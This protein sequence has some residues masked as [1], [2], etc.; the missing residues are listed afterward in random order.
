M[1]E[2]TGAVHAQVPVDVATFLLNEKRA[3]FHSI[4]QRLKVNVVLIPNIHLETPNYTVTR[5]KHEELNHADLPPPSYE[6]VAVPEKTETGVPSQQSE[7]PPRQ[8]A[9]APQ[10]RLEVSPQEKVTRCRS[11]FTEPTRV[12]VTLTRGDFHLARQTARRFHMTTR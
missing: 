11:H 4:E 2:N 9:A 6:M 12:Q 3:E 7:A 5:L 10:T 1:K 8:E